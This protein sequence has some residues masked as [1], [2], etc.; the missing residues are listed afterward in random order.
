M[1]TISK[2]CGS[3]RRCV[4]LS[5]LPYALVYIL[6]HTCRKPPSL[7]LTSRHQS[8][9]RK[10]TMPMPLVSPFAW[11][12]RGYSDTAADEI[13]AATNKVTEAATSCTNCTSYQGDHAV[14]E[15]AMTVPTIDY[16]DFLFLDEFLCDMMMCFPI[17]DTT[18]DHK[19]EALSLAALR[20]Y[21]IDSRYSY[22]NFSWDESPEGQHQH[23][24]LQVQ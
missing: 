5:S 8:P 22:S 7:L 14:E 16:S 13:K 10:S 18:T 3:P 4:G 23:S 15:K 9:P 20:K 19:K 24:S 21:T 6:V 2:F 1:F 12:P 11:S 17:V